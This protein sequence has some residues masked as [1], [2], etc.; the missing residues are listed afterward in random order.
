M[1]LLYLLRL[2]FFS[3]NIVNK[4]HWFVWFYK[5][6]YNL[7]TLDSISIRFFCT[8]FFQIESLGTQHHNQDIAHL[9]K[10]KKPIH[11]SS[12]SMS[13]SIHCLDPFVFTM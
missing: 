9:S 4:A 12:E 1:L 5:L 6:R 11:V 8:F 3:T 2:S 13:L 10:I 7:H